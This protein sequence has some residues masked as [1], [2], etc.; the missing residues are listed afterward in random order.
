MLYPESKYAKWLIPILKKIGIRY[1]DYSEKINLSEEGLRYENDFHPVP[2][3]HYRVAEE[4][5]RDL[6]IANPAALKG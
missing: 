4:L 1:L 6:G 2:R 5:V 3:G